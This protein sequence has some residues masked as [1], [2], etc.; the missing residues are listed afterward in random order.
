MSLDEPYC[1]PGCVDQRGHESHKLVYLSF[2]SCKVGVIVLELGE[3]CQLELLIPASS[4][5]MLT[6]YKTLV[7]GPTHDGVVGC[8]TVPTNTYFT[9]QAKNYVLKQRINVF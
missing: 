1:P 3:G 6:Y 4:I 2:I 9:I 7:D 5:Q 8:V